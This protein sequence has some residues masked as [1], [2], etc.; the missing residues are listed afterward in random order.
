[1]MRKHFVL[2]VAVMLALTVTITAAFLVSKAS[3]ATEKKAVA[4]VEKVGELK[5]STGMVEY[6]IFK[7]NEPG[8]TLFHQLGMKFGYPGDIIA[9]GQEAE[10]FFPLASTSEKGGFKQDVICSTNGTVELYHYLIK[11]PSGATFN[12]V[13]RKPHDE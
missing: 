2:T 10:K 7:V 8:Y 3:G 4:C 6:F 11:R 13:V 12:V 9:F 5:N 1:M